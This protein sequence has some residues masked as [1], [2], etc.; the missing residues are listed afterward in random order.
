MPGDDIKG[1]VRLGG[2][3]EGVVELADDGVFARLLFVV[4]G[5]DRSLEVAG[6]GQTIGSNGAE[7]GE[8]VVSLVQLTD[9]S[10]DRTFGE[11]NAV[12]TY[13]HKYQSMFNHIF[14]D[15]GKN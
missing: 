9:V 14:P 2:A 8:L 4:E 10:S 6:V 12:A 3:E 15:A 1:R 7:F 11:G 5:S 13:D